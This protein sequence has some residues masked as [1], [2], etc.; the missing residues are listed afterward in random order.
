MSRARAGAT[1]GTTETIDDGLVDEP[2][3]VPL[4]YS[5]DALTHRF[6][7]KH[8]DHLRFTS[9]MNTWFVY[10]GMRWVPEKTL[11]ALDEARGVCRAAAAECNSSDAVRRSI[12]SAKTVAAVEKLARADR[13]IAATDD[14]WDQDPW[15]LNTPDGVI[16]L[17]TGIMRLATPND[18]MTKITAVAPNGT[19]TMFSK[20]LFKKFLDRV[21]NGDLALQGFLRRFG[22]YCL[23]GLTIEQALAF[24][25]GTGA[26]GK[27]TFVGVLAGI[28]NDYHCTAAIE[29]FTASK[30]DHHPTDLAGL[31]GARLVTASET[32]EGR[33]WA[34]AKVKMLTGGDTIKARFMRQDYFAYEPQFK[35]MISGNHRPGLNS[36]DEAIRRR[37]CLV[38]F[39]VT[40]PAKDRDRKLA[41]KLKEEWPLILQWLIEG[42]L[43]WQ[44]AGLAPPA[45]VVEAT[46]EYLADE[47]TIESWITDRCRRDAEKWESIQK[48]YESY[49][50]WC[51]ANGE[52]VSSSKTFSLK[53]QERGF[54]SFRS[55]DDR[56]RGRLGLELLM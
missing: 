42:A 48:L 33:R 44:K 12:A 55:G 18:Y 47:D 41:A 38:P 5:D 52:W 49:S 20:S 15:L 6:V 51:K 32:E 27:G 22:G 23:T 16:D 14:Q 29:T 10:D 40:I 43:E 17:R 34:E 9:S 4:A 56:K 54:K 36:V 8:K 28:L 45:A 50:D 26:N 3:V 46:T 13:A 35:L 25:Y 19:P 30:Y 31:R 1:E 24:L 53:L 2:V 21:T 37:F 7:E 39:T 11:F